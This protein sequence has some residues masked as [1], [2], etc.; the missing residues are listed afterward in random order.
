MKVVEDRWVKPFGT[1]ISCIDTVDGECP[2]GLS[3][4]E[5]VQKCEASPYCNAGYHVSFRDIPLSSYCAPLNTIFYQNANFLDNVISPQN[6]TRLSADNGID[7]RVFYNPQRFPDNVN[8]MDTPYLFF[9]NTCFLVQDRGALG[10][11]YLHSDFVFYPLPATAMSVVLGQ[12]GTLLTDFDLRITTASELYFIKNNEFSVL[13]FDRN[14]HTFSWTPYSGTPYSY[15]F[16]DHSPGFVNEKEGFQLFNAKHQE[17]LS[18]DPSTN[19]MVWS[20]EKPVYPLSFE[21]DPTSRVNQLSRTRW[22]DVPRVFPDFWNFVNEKQVP[23]FLCDNFSNCTVR[24]ASPLVTKGAWTTTMAMVV[25]TA[26]LLLTVLV[27][28]VV[29]PG[30]AKSETARNKISMPSPSST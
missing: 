26:I 17:Y 14:L 10:K 21:L 3:L 8:L 20:K 29:A 6:K 25:L 30:K 2:R 12:S 7:V 16:R 27:I 4:E 19:K 5:C 18:V 22:N 1:G 13:F 15:A 28:F 24:T 23:Q 11:Y 9:S